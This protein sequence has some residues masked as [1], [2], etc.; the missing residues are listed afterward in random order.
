LK[1]KTKAP[2]TVKRGGKVRASFEGKEDIMSVVVGNADD[3][4]KLRCKSD[5]C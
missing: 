4:E 3:S 5:D 2:R 1:S